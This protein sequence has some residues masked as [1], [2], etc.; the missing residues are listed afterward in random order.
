VEKIDLEKLREV[1]DWS[2]DLSDELGMPSILPC[3]LV[4]K[5]ETCIDRQRRRLLEEM[6]IGKMCERCKARWYSM[7]A[8]K[9]IDT[10][11]AAKTSRPLRGPTSYASFL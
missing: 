9:K 8:H 11:Y 7:M 5:D 1:R 10:V 3:N 6:K 2:E 4:L